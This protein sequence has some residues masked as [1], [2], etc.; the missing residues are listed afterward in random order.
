MSIPSNSTSIPPKFHVL[1]SKIRC[2]F[3]QNSTSLLPKFDVYSS[4]IPCLFLQN[5]NLYVTHSFPST[6]KNEKWRH[7][8]KQWSCMCGECKRIC[9][10]TNLRLNFVY[11]HEEIRSNYVRGKHVAFQFRPCAVYSTCLSKERS[12]KYKNDNFTCYLYDEKSG[13]TLKKED[14]LPIIFEKREWRK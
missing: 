3:L 7:V 10:K 5:S 11:I 9:D 2:L 4:K 13:H 6:T 14:Y 12:P 8:R 1:S